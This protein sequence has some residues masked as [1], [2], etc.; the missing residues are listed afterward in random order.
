MT[1][2]TFCELDCMPKSFWSV[3]SMFGTVQNSPYS[4]E[5]LLAKTESSCTTY[6]GNIEYAPME[7]EN[8]KTVFL[9]ICK[10]GKS[11]EML[12]YSLKSIRKGPKKQWLKKCC[13]KGLLTLLK[14]N[15]A[16]M[17]AGISCDFKHW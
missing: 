17:K 6:I 2:L 3:V 8:Y 13:I 1:E 7:N 12:K 14:I 10:E 4:L 15:M 11:N 16:R 5:M 9:N